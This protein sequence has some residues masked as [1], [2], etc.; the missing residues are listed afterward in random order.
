MSNS[1][2]LSRP[3]VAS[4]AVSKVPVS[5]LKP[6]RRSEG[7][8]LFIVWP[9][10]TAKRRILSGRSS[11]VTGFGCVF[12]AKRRWMNR[13][14]FIGRPRGPSTGIKRPTGRSRSVGSKK[15]LTSS[16]KRNASLSN[17][18][19]SPYR[20]PRTLSINAVSAS[21][22]SARLVCRLARSSVTSRC[23]RS[24]SGSS[25]PRS[26]TRTHL[27]VRFTCVSILVS[28]F[29]SIF[30]LGRILTMMER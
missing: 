12:A 9:T 13:R 4:I 20:F 23:K 15:L 7:A 24:F 5:A 26:C 8:R 14:A 22:A 3:H 11:I 28:I 27:P 30:T 19:F 10:S 18:S 25:P 17:S 29:H 6:T 16:E 1:S 2:A 21:S